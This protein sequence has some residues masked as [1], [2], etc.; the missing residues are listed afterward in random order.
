MSVRV[1]ALCGGIGGA[2]LALGLHTLLPSGH[3][4][5]VANT[6]DDFEHLGLC[7]S[8][9]VDTVLY[10]L[11]GIANPQTGWGRAEETWHFMAEVERLGGPTWFQLGDKD[12][13]THVERTR[14]RLNGERLH[15]IIGD[16]SRRFGLA[17]TVVL[18][19]SDD[20]VRTIVHTDSGKLGF[21]DYFVARH[22][23]PTVQHIT[24]EGA[25]QAHSAG[26]VLQQLAEGSFDAVIIC[27]SNPYLSIQP[28]LAIPEWRSALQRSPAPVIA[29]SPIIAGTAVKGPTA[30]IMREL[31][32]DVSAVAI[33]RH[34]DDLIDGFVLDEADASC[35]AQLTVRAITTR[36][37]M[38]T[39][40]DKQSL[41]QR[42][43]QFAAALR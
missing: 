23:A 37:L 41:A 3:L 31:G 18:P 6:G 43:L 42:V 32:V 13:A 36:T 2:K 27:P 8:P 28:L 39:L 16:F 20:R 30:K 29:I 17:G 35:V 7:I 11:A 26:T 38:H 24:Y 19:M 9:D 34:Y 12:L 40:A 22:C 1:L 4:T 10:T 21:Q 14:R 33:A 15:E 5:V 25:E